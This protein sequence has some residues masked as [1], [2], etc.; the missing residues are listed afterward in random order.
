M[1]ASAVC[2]CCD[3][4]A[5]KPFI[6]FSAVPRTGLFP[7]LPPAVAPRLDLDFEYCASC[8][9]IRR[10]RDGLPDPDYTDVARS[11]AAQLPAYLDSV[12]D[13]FA[14]RCPDRTRLVVDIGGNDGSFLLRLQRRGYVQT[15]N[16]EPSRILARRSEAAGCPTLRAPFDSAAAAG[17]AGRHGRAGAIFLRH[18]LEHVADPVGLLRAVHDLLADDGIFYLELPD[19]RGIVERGLVHELWEEHLYYHSLSTIALLLRKTGFTVLGQAV[20]PHRGGFNL[21]F[22]ARRRKEDEAEDH[23]AVRLPEGLRSFGERWHRACFALHRAA[24]GWRPPVYLLGASH[25]Q[26]NFI[27]YS[28]LSRHVS[29]AVDDDPEK[30]GRFLNMTPPVPILST[31]HFE[32]TATGGALLLTAWGCAAWTER[33]QKIAL[34][35]GMQVI[36]PLEPFTW[37]PARKLP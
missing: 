15:L 30:I 18:V 25:P 36:D 19:S 8:G 21:L 22:Q 29:C 34:V 24:L 2:P 10:R 5:W 31:R 4:V 14:A 1:P 16:V 27:H 28:G 33:A 37:G 23:V 17:I 6:T 20:H 35:K 12:E 3:A 7:N 9:L 26:T 32:E 13:A 11:T